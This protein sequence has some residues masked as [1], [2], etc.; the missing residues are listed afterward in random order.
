MDLFPVFRL[1]SHCLPG[2][3][4]DIIRRLR[5]EMADYELMASEESASIETLESMPYLNNVMKEVLR[6]YP[7][8]GGGYRKVLKT[9]VVNVSAMYT[10][11]ALTHGPCIPVMH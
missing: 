10:C 3:N 6:V 11:D 5:E 1:N 2:Q 9:F 4:K 8:I 7:P